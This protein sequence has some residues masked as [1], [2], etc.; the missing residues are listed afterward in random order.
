MFVACATRLANFLVSVVSPIIDLTSPRKT[1]L[2]GSRESYGFFF[3]SERREWYEEVQIQ[4]GPNC[5][6][7]PANRAAGRDGCRGDA[8]AGDQRSDV[9]QLEEE[10]RRSG[11][12]GTAPLAAIGRWKPAA[13]AIGGRSVAGQTIVAGCA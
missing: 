7:H 13:Q 10:V 9:L 4:R 5:V 3:F 12:F 8:E 11:R 2:L 1:G 6:R